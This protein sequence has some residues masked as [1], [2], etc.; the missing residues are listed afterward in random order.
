VGY[1][2]KLS[3]TTKVEQK[4]LY[5]SQTVLITHNDRPRGFSNGDLIW[6]N[7]NGKSRLVRLGSKSC[8]PKSIAIW[9]QLRNEFGLTENGEASF[10]I[11]KANLEDYP[12]WVSH[13]PDSHERFRILM[14]TKAAQSAKSASE[15]SEEMNRLTKVLVEEVRLERAAAT[16]ERFAAQVERQQASKARKWN[17]AY[18]IGFGF[19][20]Y[21]AGYV[22]EGVLDQ[23][24]VKSWVVSQIFS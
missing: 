18:G 19:L 23:T 11:S 22:L 6:L 21:L 9:D 14:V 8:P 10:S 16:K 20:A 15:L 7:C 4:D 3:V 12:E 5:F 2:L 24:S 13:L 17:V 1:N